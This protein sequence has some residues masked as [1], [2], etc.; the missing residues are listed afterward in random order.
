MDGH[1]E[2]TVKE[3]THV[4]FNTN[5]QTYGQPKSVVVEGALLLNENLCRRK[6]TYFNTLGV[7]CGKK[8]K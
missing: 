8:L 2:E 5:K 1:R 4:F 7:A 6:K 3:H